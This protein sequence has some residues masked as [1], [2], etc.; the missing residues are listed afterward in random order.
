ML[1]GAA[2]LAAVAGSR[3]WLLTLTAG[4]VTTLEL[5]LEGLTA[6]LECLDEHVARFPQAFARAPT[7]TLA[8]CCGCGFSWSQVDVAVEG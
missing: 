1:C 3:L 4:T 2:D 6:F 5:L 8:G 7:F